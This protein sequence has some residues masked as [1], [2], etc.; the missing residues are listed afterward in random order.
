MNFL[1][2][3]IYLD[4]VRIGDSERCYVIAE[5]GHNH[6]GSL[7][8]AKEM[9]LSAKQCGADAVKFQK[10]NNKTLFTKILY[11]SPYTSENSYGPTYGAHRE[12][13][14]FS[15]DQYKELASFCNE[16]KISFFATAFDFESADFLEEVNI[17]FYKIA[18]ADLQNTPLLRYVAKFGKPI[19]LSTGGGTIDDVQ[20][21]Y[22][23]IMPINTQLVI[24]QCTAS[25]PVEKY[26]EMDLRVI[27][28]YLS[29]FPDAVVGLSDHEN[30]IGMALVAFA[31]GARVVEKHFTLNRAWRGTDHAFSLAP[32][33]MQK[34]VRDLKR[35]GLALG[36][37][38]KRRH[39]SEEKPLL[40]MSK[41][42]VAA[43]DLPAG[44]VLTEADLALKSP[45]GGTPPYEMDNLVGRR[46]LVALQEDQGVSLD[47]VEPK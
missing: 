15:I 24:L 1:N 41:Q 32:T 21:A 46:T 36:D 9:I 6:Q 22:D 19:I 2:R 4:G 47:A 35:A 14:E 3:H 37:G 16:Q 28:T 25:Y 34:L 5:I 39:P 33:G 20:R 45:G 31:L 13:L 12:A 10:R 42:I 23:A 17:P 11:E 27:Q 38:M 40:K 26:E 43:R 18:S 30:G 8:T 7:D 29:R 44:H